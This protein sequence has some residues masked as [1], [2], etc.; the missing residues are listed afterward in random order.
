MRPE[1]ASKA[2]IEAAADGRPHAGSFVGDELPRK[3]SSGG[4][5]LGEISSWLMGEDAK[6]KGKSDAAASLALMT[7]LLSAPAGALW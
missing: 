6:G 3:S 5:G 7:H 1:E 2:A 4:G